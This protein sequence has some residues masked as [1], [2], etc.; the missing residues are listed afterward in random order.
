M[1]KR[2]EYGV[3]LLNSPLN[4]PSMLRN[5][6][7]DF[8]LI[9]EILLRGTVI[10]FDIFTL[11]LK[12]WWGGRYF[13][14][15]VF[16]HLFAIPNYS[17]INAKIAQLCIQIQTSPRVVICLLMTWLSWCQQFTVIITLSQRFYIFLLRITFVFR[18]IRF[19]S[20]GIFSSFVNLNFETRLNNWSQF[21][22]VA[23]HCI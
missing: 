19:I 15:Q 3:P 16:A 14:S 5:V 1:A 17:H 20:W 4:S 21:S 10:N 6:L 13:S 22:T 12:L 9:S 2:S 23:I 7:L 18:V 11:L 8:L